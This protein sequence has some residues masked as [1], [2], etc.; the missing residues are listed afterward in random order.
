LVVPSV[1]IGG[2]L[3]AGGDASPWAR[4][5]APLFGARPASAGVPAISEG[6]TSA[7]VLVAVVIGFAIAWQRYATA[8]ARRDAVARLSDESS[9]MPALLTNR[10]YFDAVIDFVFVRSAQSLGRLFG[11]ILD[12]HVIDGAVR[13]IV[14]VTRWFG[15]LVRSFQTGLLRA[16]ALIL[17]FGAACF[18][19]YYALAGAAH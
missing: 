15:T 1:A 19:A 16:Y 13:E 18:I 6:L 10:F 8:A 12:P 5:F 2:A 14:H 4:Y 3:M 9:R 7:L 11:S 17:V